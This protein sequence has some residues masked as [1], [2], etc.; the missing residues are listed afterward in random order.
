MNALLLSTSL[1]GLTLVA[2]E[3]VPAM[4]VNLAEMVSGS[5]SIMNVVDLVNDYHVAM[6]T[7]QP[8][9]TRRTATV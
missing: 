4:V 6:A 2:P 5:V 9:W 3:S 1:V 7:W 8:R